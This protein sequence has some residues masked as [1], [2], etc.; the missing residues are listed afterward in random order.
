MPVMPPPAIQPRGMIPEP[1]RKRD[2][3][4]AEN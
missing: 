2:E 4:D 1:Q 3:Q